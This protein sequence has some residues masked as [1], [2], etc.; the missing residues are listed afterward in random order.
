[1]KLKKKSGLMGAVIA[2]SAAS[3][4][5][6]GFASWVIS[7]GDQKVMDGTVFVDEVETRNRTIVNNSAANQIVSFAAPAVG[8]GTWLSAVG[9]FTPEQLKIVLS[10]DVQNVNEDY[11]GATV[12][13][14]IEGGDFD[15]AVDANL[16]TKPAQLENVVP[17]KGAFAQD[18]TKIDAESKPVGT[19]SYSL[20]FTF[21]WGTEF[22]G[23]NPY[24]FYNGKTPSEATTVENPNSDTT[25]K[26]KYTWAELAAVRLGELNDYLTGVTYR[27][28]IKAA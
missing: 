23:V 7:Q 25:P 22:G 24:T 2:L 5:S 9:E 14:A 27:V 21:G 8:Q 10:F 16:V 13:L 19:Q 4:V 18:G 15:G 1:M 11:A 26:A 3:L 17:A 28:T 6:V 12:S 20:T